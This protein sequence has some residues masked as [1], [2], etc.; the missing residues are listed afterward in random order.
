MRFKYFALTA[1]LGGAH[2]KLRELVAWADAW[3]TK[4]FGL[5]LLITDVARTLAEERNL[6]AGNPSTMPFG[7]GP[8]CTSQPRAADIAVR[9]SY[10]A[11]TPE[12][13]KRLAR[14]INDNW[15]Y[16]PD[17]RGFRCA[18]VHDVGSGNHLHLQVHDH[19]TL[20]TPDEIKTHPVIEPDVL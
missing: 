18:I 13:A 10:G 4:S 8:H 11:L 20:N 15:I 5:D 2:P 9:Q 16:D 3:A 6:Y 12:Q 1:E 14:E 19:T 17:R 7:G